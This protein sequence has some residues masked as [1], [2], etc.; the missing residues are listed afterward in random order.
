MHH[1]HDHECCG[2]GTCE[3]VAVDPR[4]ADDD[5]TQAASHERRVRAAHA[6]GLSL[7]FGLLGGYLLL[8]VVG[9]VCGG[10]R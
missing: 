4:F 6:H 8:R 10:R 9:R 7:I 3:S 1:H 2:T 5:F